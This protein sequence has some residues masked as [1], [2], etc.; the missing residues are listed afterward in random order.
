MGTITS[1]LCLTS[2]LCPKNMSVPARS[3]TTAS[4]FS[5]CPL[6]SINPWRVIMVLSNLPELIDIEGSRRVVSMRDDL[7]LSEVISAM[8]QVEIYFL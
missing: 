2:Q 3:V 4:S 7:S 1:G 8:S 6:I 5:L